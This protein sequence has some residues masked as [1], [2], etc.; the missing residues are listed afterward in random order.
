MSTERPD[1]LV[2][3]QIANRGGLVVWARDL[4]A[5]AELCDA[6]GDELRETFGMLADEVDRLR[7][8]RALLLKAVNAAESVFAETP[9]RAIAA[10]YVAMQIFE[11]AVRE[12]REAHRE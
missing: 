3:D 1:S 4:A 8:E 2:P 9:V 5:S 12:Y 6:T 10:C 11:D 7:A